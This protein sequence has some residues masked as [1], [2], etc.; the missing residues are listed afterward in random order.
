LGASAE[1]IS[2]DA[3]S[4]TLIEHALGIEKVTSAA[5]QQHEQVVKQIGGLFVDP[6]VGLLARRTGDLLCLLH[7]LLA[8]MSRIV[9]Q[10]D[11][12]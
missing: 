3:L 5:M 6:R 8:D 11:R 7:H 10:L 9:E 1:E 2:A 4:A 12:I